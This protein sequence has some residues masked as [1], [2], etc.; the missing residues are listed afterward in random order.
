MENTERYTPSLTLLSKMGV[1][2]TAFHLE[3]KTAEFLL[4]RTSLELGRVTSR[5][6]NP[7]SG[8]C[9]CARA[10]F[11]IPFTLPAPPVP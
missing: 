7:A 3:Q 1:S 9:I 8:C 2:L 11:C 5:R 6:N 10:P 4:H